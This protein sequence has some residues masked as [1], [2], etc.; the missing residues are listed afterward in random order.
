MLTPL[1]QAVQAL[2]ILQ[3]ATNPILVYKHSYKGELEEREGA[4]RREGY[5]RR[6]SKGCKEVLGRRGGAVADVT[7]MTPGSSLINEQCW[8]EQEH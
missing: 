8:S 4:V 6:E 2:A 3:A 1:Y 7:V 5:M